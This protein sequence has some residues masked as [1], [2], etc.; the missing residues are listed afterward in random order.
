MKSQIE[1]FIWVAFIL[2]VGILSFY[3]YI[4]YQSFSYQG[5]L[6]SMQEESCQNLFDKINYVCYSYT[7]TSIYMNFYATKYF[8]KL[9]FINNTV[10][11]SYYN[12]NNSKNFDCNVI[13]NSS[14]PIEYYNNGLYYTLSGGKGYENFNLEIYKYNSTTVKIKVIPPSK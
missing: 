11:C 4:K 1:R 7:G 3:I 9:Y 10:Y 6:L 2:I 12:N 13:Y 14:I 8:N 5:Q